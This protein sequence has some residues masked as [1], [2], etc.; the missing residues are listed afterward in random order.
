MQMFGIQITFSQYHQTNT[1]NE[2]PHMW[3][4]HLA[5]SWELHNVYGSYIHYVYGSYTSNTSQN[6][7]CC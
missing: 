1:E 4:E 5:E 6:S 2:M 3:G 7:G